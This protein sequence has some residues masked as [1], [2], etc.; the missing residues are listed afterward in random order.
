MLRATWEAYSL[1]FVFEAR[2]SRAVMH[3]K[4]TYFVRLWDDAQPDV[5]AVGE[6]ALFRGLSREDD[7]GYE[8]R[9]GD[10]CADPR[11]ALLSA[12]SSIRFGFEGAFAALERARGV[13]VADTPWERGEV[14]IPINGLVWMGDKELMLNRI[15]EKLDQGFR[16]LKL[17]I[18]GID[19]DDEIELIKMIRR[20][21]PADSLELRLDANGAFGTENVM[22]RLEQLSKYQIHS[23]EQPVMAGQYDL[24]AKVCSESPIQVA[25]DEELIGVTTNDF[26]EQLLGYV[27]PAY[28]ILKPSLCG[29][30][31]EADSWIDCAGKMGIGW[32]ATSA[33]ESNVGLEEIA[34]WLSRKD[35]SMPQGLGTGQLYD[36]NVGNEMKIIGDKLFLRI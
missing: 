29:G 33:L 15:K 23:I 1:N 28:I 31:R 18:G 25:L 8:Q 35:I 17:K 20:R 27:R 7:A 16:C 5:T 34:R 22:H 32:W 21:F 10:A 3:K 2:T 24:M 14:G 4:D 26:K 9:L 12:D 11:A 30:L 13:A 19:F 36:N 6:C